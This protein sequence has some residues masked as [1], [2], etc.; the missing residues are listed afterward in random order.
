VKKS[1]L[2]V[3]QRWPSTSEKTTS[4][5]TPTTTKA[6][7]GREA[8]S[9]VPKFQKNVLNF[10]RQADGVAGKVRLRKSVFHR[11]SN[12]GLGLHNLSPSASFELPLQLLTQNEDVATESERREEQ[13]VPD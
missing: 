2:V 8:T 3:D 9:P 11:V 5:A 13:K 10:E 6:S 7:T 12:E 4:F 1:S